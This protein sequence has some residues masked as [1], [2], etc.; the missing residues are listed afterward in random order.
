M[1]LALLFL[2]LAATGARADDERRE[3]LRR[4]A[5]APAPRHEQRHTRCREKEGGKEP[6]SRLLLQEPRREDGREDRVH[7][8]EQDCRRERLVRDGTLVAAA[9]EHQ[10]VAPGELLALETCQVADD[11]GRRGVDASRPGLQPAGQQ[12]G[13]EGAQVHP[14]G[15][16]A[17]ARH[18]H[19]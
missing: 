11:E 1:R 16:S 15:L 6:L 13:S 5:C 18:R 14:G 12:S 19:A 4:R 17:Q 7:L 8:L 10:G 3:R 9:D 2:A